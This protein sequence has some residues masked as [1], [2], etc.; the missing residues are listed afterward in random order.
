[1]G[2]V[3]RGVG[4]RDVLLQGIPTS[5]LVSAYQ[6]GMPLP[7]GKFGLTKIPEA[8]WKAISEEYKLC[9]F[10]KN[11]TIFACKTKEEAEEE[12]K[13]RFNERLGFEQAD[14]KRGNTKPVDD[15]E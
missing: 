7:A 15:K 9:D 8:D 1:M 5:K 10:I 11:R 2:Q 3:L 13:A 14:P 12:G 6:D 4:G